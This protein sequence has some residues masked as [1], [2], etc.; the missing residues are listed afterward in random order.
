MGKREGKQLK[1][2]FSDESQRRSFC[3]SILIIPLW[4]MF[5]PTPFAGVCFFTSVKF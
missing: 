1:E 2:N 4:A 3:F 5:E